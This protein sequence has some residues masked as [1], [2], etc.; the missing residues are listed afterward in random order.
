MGGK[1]TLGVLA[2]AILAFAGVDYATLPPPLPSYAQTRAAWHPSESWLYDRHGRLIDSARVDFAARRLAWTPLDAVSPVTRETIVAA[3]D[4]RFY[5]HGGVDSLALLGA[6]RDRIRGRRHRGASTLSMQLAG[7]L[8]PD[9]AAPGARGWWDKLRQMRAGWAIERGWRKDEILEAYLNLAGF[10]GEAQGIGAAALGLFGKTPGS[11]ARDDAVLLAALLPEPQAPAPRVARRACSLSGAKDCARF[12]GAAASMLGPARSLALDPGL[13]PHLSQRLLLRAGMR[14]TTTLDARV[15]QAAIVALKRQL[16]GLGGSRARDGAVV[17]VDN[18]SGDVLA[19]VGGIGGNSTAAAV[20]GA[21]SY[22]QAGSTLKPFLYAQAIERG[23]L[24]PASIL[25]DSPVQLDTASGLYVPQNYDH[26]FKGPVSARSALAGSL[27]VP[28]VRTL[29]LVGVE[30]FRDRLWDSGYRGLTE[31][32]QYYGFSLALGSA[33]V[34][35]LEQAD[36]YRALANGGQ[37]TPLRLTADA[38]R[39]AARRITSAQAAWLVSDMIADPDARAATFGMD[40]AL[41]LPFWA[42][43]KTGTSKAMRDNWC[44]G[45]SDRYTVGVWVGNLE[46]DPMRAVSGTSG[47]APVWRDLMLALHGARAGQAPPR[48]EG[49]EQRLVS[50]GD[51]IERARPEYFLAGTGQSQIAA[52]PAAARRPRIVNPV[53]G[54]VY[55]LDPDIPIERQRLAIGVSGAVS[56]HRLMLDAKNLGAADAHPLVLAGPGKHRLRLIDLTGRV[57]DQVIFTIR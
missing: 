17:V 7:F 22:R 24:T 34:T 57:I 3:E 9:L 44:I 40:S 43:V 42:A 37:W 35:L 6:L 48:P 49:I 15:Q 11:L 12:P 51:G 31:D 56:A 53:S 8:A 16:Q 33:E 39:P 21:N 47:A 38:P 23:Y 25:D 27:N 13:A 46:G 4:R 20:D 55:A 1:V 5:G 19:Y 50:F 52:A 28:A 2:A 45:Y 14:V 18:A 29:L 26:A 30:P 54:S 41:R 36:A 10:R 32:G